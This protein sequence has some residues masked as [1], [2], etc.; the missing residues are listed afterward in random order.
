MTSIAILRVANSRGEFPRWSPLIIY[1][2]RP[3][4]MK[5]FQF[6]RSLQILL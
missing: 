5:D 4:I 6:I 3:H 1:K 2:L